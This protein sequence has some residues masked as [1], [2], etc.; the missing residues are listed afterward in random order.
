MDKIMTITNR[1][2]RLNGEM[3]DIHDT[4]YRVLKL[5]ELG[6]NGIEGEQELYNAMMTRIKSNNVYR[7]DSRSFYES[8]YLLNDLTPDEYLLILDKSCEMLGRNTDQVL[9]PNELCDVMFSNI[10]ES[11]T[12]VFIPDAEKFGVSLYRTIEKYPKVKFYTSSFSY[13][14]RQLLELIYKN[15]NVQFINHDIYKEDFIYQK[16]DIIVCFPILGARGLEGTG[17]F[18]SR[19]SALIAAQNLLYHLTP[20][21]KLSIILP[22]KVTFGGGDSEQFRDYINSNYKIDG[23]YSLPN[24]IFYPQMAINTYLFDLANGETE[25]V[26]VRKYSIENNK[27]TL[28][29]DNQKLL[30]IDEFE[31]LNDWAIDVAFIEEDDELINYRESNIKKER[32]QQVANV[33]RGKAVTNKVENGNIAVINISDINENGIDYLKLDTINEEERKIS[34][35]IL[36]ENDVLITSRGTN[37]KIGVFTKQAKICIPSSNINVVRTDSKILF[38]PYLKL[39]LESRV[40]IKLLQ[41]IQRGSAIVNINFQ[42]I[43]MLEV[44]IPPIER[45]KE[46][47]S[48][49]CEGLVK[50]K[51]IVQKAE[52]EWYKLKEHVHAKLF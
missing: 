51:D 26:L 33:F 41:T 32:V 8:F 47:V 37:I 14:M 39:F 50:Y 11:T 6:F 9:I 35:Y 48:E 40:G 22:A 42:D 3:F 7:G 2:R 36:E 17:Q 45:Q 52:E 23:I 29:D 25:D 27:L 19:D 21:G 49:Y 24:R 43:E 44:P 4:L 1:I 38:G 18:I 15:E 13:E 34:R 16:F 30:F 46:I 12:S 10:S 28:N 31:A 20:K 5:K